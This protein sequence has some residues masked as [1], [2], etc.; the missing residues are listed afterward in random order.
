MKLI[1][2]I[3]R[4]DVPIIKKLTKLEFRNRFTF[5][6][7][8]AIEEVSIT[9]S[10][11]RV[12]QTNLNIAEFIDVKDPNTIAGINYLVSKELLTQE[13]ADIILGN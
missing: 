1:E 8:V 10:G 12:L 13:R 5:E 6:E 2:P 7:L 4:T 9:D 11:V 3:K